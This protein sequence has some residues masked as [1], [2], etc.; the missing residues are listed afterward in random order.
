VVA[1]RYTRACSGSVNASWHSSSRGVLPAFK[2]LCRANLRTS[3]RHIASAVLCWPTIPAFLQYAWATIFYY[4][5]NR[6][7]AAWLYAVIVC[8]SI[9]LSQVVVLQTVSYDSPGTPS[10]PRPKKSWRNSN[11]ITP[12]WVPNRGRVGSNGDFRPLSHYISE[13][14]QDRDIVTTER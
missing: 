3:S 10:F 11:R 7:C 4:V 6:F 12:T 5:L 9:R 8:L 13:T 2:W 1:I 14:V